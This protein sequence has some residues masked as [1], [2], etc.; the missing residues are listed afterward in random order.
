VGLGFFGSFDIPPQT[1]RVTDPNLYMQIGSYWDGLY[2]E[3]VSLFKALGI[4]RVD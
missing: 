1:L 3:M 2:A 4:F